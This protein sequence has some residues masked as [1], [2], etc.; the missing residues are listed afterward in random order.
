MKALTIRQPWASL[1]AFRLKRFE[2]R[3][4]KTKF[5]GKLAIHA[6]KYSPEKITHE[7]EVQKAMYDALKP[8]FF[9]DAPADWSDVERA[10]P[11]GGIIAIVDIVDLWKSPENGDPDNVQIY[12]NG[13]RG[14]GKYE[15]INPPELLFGDFSPGRFALEADN[16]ILLPKPI[17]CNGRQGLW[18]CSTELSNAYYAPNQTEEM[19]AILREYVIP[20]RI[21]TTSN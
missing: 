13:G 16:V 8:M 4:W 15:T 6:G 10:C 18:N 17:Y 1:Y 2:T 14:F 11:L 21:A 3:G 12:G 19:K 20:E 7:L 9:P 5:R